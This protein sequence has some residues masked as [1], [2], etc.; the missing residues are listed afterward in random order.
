MPTK[1]RLSFPTKFAREQNYYEVK[2][3]TKMYLFDQ[4][5]QFIY[6]VSFKLGQVA[7]DGLDEYVFK[8]YSSVEKQ[9]F[10]SNYDILFARRTYR[11][12]GAPPN[13]PYLCQ[14]NAA[15]TARNPDGSLNYTSAKITQDRRISELYESYTFLNDQLVYDPQLVHLAFRG[16]K[17]FDILG[18]T[19]L[20]AQTPPQGP[21]YIVGAT[22]TGSMTATDT[23]NQAKVEVF[24][25]Y[26][27]QKKIA[28]DIMKDKAWIRRFA[29]KH[30]LFIFRSNNVNKN[31]R[32]LYGFPVKDLR[33]HPY[34]QVKY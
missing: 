14:V 22:D 1:S 32:I 3:G 17:E 34:D 19:A 28:D 2:D 15:P 8:S 20:D 30:F 13:D 4:I 6:K 10:L 31:P 21:S 11:E 25:P 24:I 27:D 29:Q 16:K 5:T 18:S 26:D 7:G 12:V 9:F 23:D 33:I